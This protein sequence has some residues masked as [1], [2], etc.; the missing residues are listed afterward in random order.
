MKTAKGAKFDLLVAAAAKTLSDALK[1]KNADQ[2]TLFVY[3]DRGSAVEVFWE[4]RE[5]LG[6]IR[7]NEPVRFGRKP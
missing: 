3:S 7:P 2:L 6:E 1:E 4:E 5:L